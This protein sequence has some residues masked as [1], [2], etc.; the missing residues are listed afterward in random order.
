MN[1]LS[2]QPSPPWRSKI[3]EA[4]SSNP[5]II[6]LV[7]LVTSPHFEAI[8]GPTM[9]HLINITKMILSFWEFQEVLKLCA[10]NQGQTLGIFFIIK[11]E[12]L[13]FT[14]HCTFNLN[15]HTESISHYGAQ[16][17]LCLS[18]NFTWVLSPKIYIM[19][20]LLYSRLF[21]SVFQETSHQSWNSCSL[22]ILLELL[23][24]LGNR[25]HGWLFR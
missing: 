18:S 4:Q 8:Y 16:A 23:D 17:I 3:G 7:S 22:I 12:H 5:L 2:L 13:N 24:S 25:T 1:K 10:R 9:C 6:W 15:K 14:I 19:I 21:S 11:R 20:C